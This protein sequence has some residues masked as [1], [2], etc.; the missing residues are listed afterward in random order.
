[1]TSQDCV[2]APMLPAEPPPPTISRRWLVAIHE[3]GHLAAI[4]L[5]K[6]ERFV[7]ACVFDDCG[8]LLR[9][10]FRNTNDDD[11]PEESFVTAAGPAAEWLTDRLPQPATLPYDKAQ[12]PS[13]L[14]G[15]E[16]HARV[17]SECQRM[18]S[19]EEWLKEWAGRGLERHP[20]HLGTD[21][22]SLP[23]VRHEAYVFVEEHLHLIGRIAEWLYLHGYIGPT[24]AEE[25]FRAAGQ[26]TTERES[27]E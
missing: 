17:V 8:S 5:I 19:D 4:W 27:H 16:G 18:L 7:G 20:E 23:G 13:T 21:V 3:G 1:M 2:A 22:Y 11:S 12:L 26:S 14:S 24:D 6:K 9:S 25:I 10:L 15:P